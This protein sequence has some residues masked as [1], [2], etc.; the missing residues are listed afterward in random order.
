[1]LLV[2]MFDCQMFTLACPLFQP[3]C[4]WILGGDPCCQCRCAGVLTN[5]VGQTASLG[6]KHSLTVVTLPSE[7]R[8]PKK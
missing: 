4:T 1:M 3:G 5:A 6:H 7:W 8:M 2:G